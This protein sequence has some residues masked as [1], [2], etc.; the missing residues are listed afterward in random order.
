[1]DNHLSRRQLYWQKLCATHKNEISYGEI[2]QM[3]GLEAGKITLKD[4]HLVWWANIIFTNFLTTNKLGYS[5][6][7]LPASKPSI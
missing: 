2:S 4:Y 1:M 3:D 7:I 6:V 5:E